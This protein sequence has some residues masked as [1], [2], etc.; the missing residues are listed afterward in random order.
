MTSAPEGSASVVIVQASN[1]NRRGVACHISPPRTRSPRA[2]NPVPAMATL[3]VQGVDIPLQLIFDRLPHVDVS[4]TFGAILLGNFV[5]LT[6]FG[7]NLH[8]TFRYFR[9]F[10]KDALVLQAVVIA[11]LISEILH[12]I[13]GIHI[14]YYYLISS[15]FRP[16]ALLEG[17][18]SI[19]L[20][21]LNMGIVMFISQSFFARRVYLIGQHHKILAYVT[22]VLLLGEL[23]FATASTVETYIQVTFQKFTGY[24][25][26]I[27]CGFAMAFLADGLVAVSL[28]TVLRR[29][30]ANMQRT[31]SLFDVMLV[32]SVNTG[33]LTC[34][35]SIFSLVF[36]VVFPANLI[37][38]GFNT[39]VTR[40]YAN[41]LLAVLNSR[42]SAVDHGIEGFETGSLGLAAYQVKVEKVTA[43][44]WNVPQVPAPQPT[45]ID[46]KV[47]TEMVNDLVGEEGEADSQKGPA[48]NI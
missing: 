6:L 30:R 4:S 31:D 44:Q 11:T 1:S 16:T 13:M 41:A 27:P 33:A 19:K 22:G 29:S 20:L 3:S 47:T 9:L 2:R 23:A 48:F 43:E 5:G 45:I 18:W 7:V 46:I 25:W 40:L 21:S 10:P 37:Y 34:V 42:R 15:Y 26:L 8:Q 39:V 28:T 12:T 14:C 17:V 24:A 36:G 38:A 35:L 32:Y